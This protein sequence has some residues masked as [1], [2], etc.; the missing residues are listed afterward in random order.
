MGLNN[1]FKVEQFVFTSLF[2]HGSNQSYQQVVF[3]RV[4]HVLDNKSIYSGV[5]FF[6]CLK[7]IEAIRLGD[8]LSNLYK[9]R[10]L[11]NLQC[12]LIGPLSY[13]IHTTVLQLNAYQSPY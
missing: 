8:L 6:S 12:S 2:N 9:L 1:I 11:H 4:A 7:E 3:Y 10:I 13:S 5:F